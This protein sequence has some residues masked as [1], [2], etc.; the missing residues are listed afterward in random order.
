MCV[1]VRERERDKD[2]SRQTRD[3]TQNNTFILSEV[4]LESHR[5]KQVLGARCI[6]ALLAI[7]AKISNVPLGYLCTAAAE[8]EGRR[9]RVPVPHPY[10]TS[11]GHKT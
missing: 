1:C 7:C 6:H 4:T 11:V 10:A 5:D 9:M 8:L 3:G 2:K